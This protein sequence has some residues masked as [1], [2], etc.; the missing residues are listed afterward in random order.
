MANY[1]DSI[2]SLQLRNERLGCEF[3]DLSFYSP[4]VL[5]FRPSDFSQK[6]GIFWFKSVSWPKDSRAAGIVHPSLRSGSVASAST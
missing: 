5:Y 1:I 4:Y 2:T 3:S 6:E